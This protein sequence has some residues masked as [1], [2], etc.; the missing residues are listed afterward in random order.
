MRLI[1][2]YDGTTFV[3]CKDG[4]FKIGGAAPE[5]EISDADY[6]GAECYF[7]SPH[8]VSLDNMAAIKAGVVVGRTAENELLVKIDVN[9]TGETED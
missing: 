3:I 1:T 6:V 5:T 7:E 9:E 8:A 2:S 4:I